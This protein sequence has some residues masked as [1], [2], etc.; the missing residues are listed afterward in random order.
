MI[1]KSEPLSLAEVKE[2]VKKMPESPILEKI[3]TY[4]KKFVKINEREAEKL[5][6]ELQESF[7]NLASKDIVKIIDILP[8]DAEDVRKIFADTSLDENEIKKILEIVKK[9]I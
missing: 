1:K 3:N 8:P 4:I 9:Y 5:K 6:K 7:P 2:L